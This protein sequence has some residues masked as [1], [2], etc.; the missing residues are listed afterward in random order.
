MAKAKDQSN[1]TRQEITQ[2]SISPSIIH[3]MN[4]KLDLILAQQDNIKKGEDLPEFL[5]VDEVAALLGKSPHTIRRMVE[6]KRL[7]AEPRDARCKILITRE[8]ITRYRN[9]LAKGK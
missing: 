7:K 1:E 4:K 2:I 3:E 5:E 6:S 8:E 9:K